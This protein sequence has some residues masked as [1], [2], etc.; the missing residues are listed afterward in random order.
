MVKNGC[1]RKAQREPVPETLPTSNIWMFSAKVQLSLQLQIACNAS[2]DV[3]LRT[4]PMYGCFC[5]TQLLLQLQILCNASTNVQRRKHP[6]IGCYWRT[7]NSY[8]NEI[9]NVS[10]LHRCAIL[11]IILSHGWSRWYKNCKII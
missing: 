7:C 4:H 5:R 1:A 8:N 3:Q 9:L 6:I 2:T 10:S 11:T